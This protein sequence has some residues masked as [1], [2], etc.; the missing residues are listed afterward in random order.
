MGSKANGVTSVHVTPL[1][2]RFRMYEMGERTALQKTVEGEG[3]QSV[4]TETLA[5]REWSAHAGVLITARTSVAAHVCDGHR[6][7]EGMGAGGR[8]HCP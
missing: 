8:A 5:C 6:L 4:S 1:C 3:M 2:L 7:P